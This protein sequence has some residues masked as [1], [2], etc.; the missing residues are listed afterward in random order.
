MVESTCI[1]KNPSSILLQVTNICMFKCKMCWEW[2]CK[3]DP[4]ELS[5]K[6]W[7]DFAVSLKG[8]SDSPVEIGITG[9]EPLLKEGVLDLIKICSESGLRTV[10]TTNGYLIDAEMAKKIV[11]SGLTLIFLSL[12]SLDEKIHDFLRGAEGAY[13][14]V[15]RAIDCLDKVRDGLEIGIQTLM[16]G[17]NLDGIIKLMEWINKDDRINTNYVQAINIPINSPHDATWYKKNEFNFLWPSDTQKVNSILD[18]LIRQKKNKSK[19]SNSISHIQSFKSYFLAPQNFMRVQQCPFIGTSLNVSAHGDV[20]LCWEKESLGNI[21]TDDI[22]QLWM[23]AKA[24]QIREEMHRCKKDCPA[25]INCS[26]K[27]KDAI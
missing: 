15:M 7:K 25:V 22:C 10:L 6:Q 21:K 11:E 16:T 14:R 18:E 9:G 4:D 3:P 23:S 26:F 12:D 1:I 20:Y 5:I 13:A 19:I 17:T 2:K 8:Y 27:E 24:G